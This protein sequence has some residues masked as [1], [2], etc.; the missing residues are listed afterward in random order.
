MLREDFN[1]GLP[2]VQSRRPDI[3]CQ[4]H[5]G[6]RCQ[7]VDLD[8]EYTQDLCHK[9]MRRQTKASGE[10]SLE[11]DQL[12]FRLGDLLRPG[13]RATPPPKYP[14]CCM[15]CTRTE[16]IRDA[17]N[18]TV[19]PGRNSSAPHCSASRRTMRRPA[20]YRQ[21]KRKRKRTAWLRTVG[22]GRRSA[23]H[24]PDLRRAGARRA[25]EQA[26]GLKWK[27]GFSRC[28]GKIKFKTHHPHPL[29]YTGRGA[30]GNPQSNSAVSINGHVKK[31]RGT[32]SSEG[33]VST[34]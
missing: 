30:S 9:S 13:T 34:I 23:S 26:S 24:G 7:L 17:P 31:P 21:Q 22:G 14:S 11:Y 20:V 3:F 16:D 2:A 1:K 12:A 29:L 18:S 32:T 6:I 8:L 25:D 15:S 4:G 19:S 10:K 5:H 28:Y 27:L 33:S